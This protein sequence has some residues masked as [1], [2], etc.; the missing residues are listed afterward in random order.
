MYLTYCTVC[1]NLIM[2]KNR[3]KLYIYSIK[4]H[5]IAG[6]GNIDEIISVVGYY[7]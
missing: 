1:R 7:Y 4:L 6:E 2:L 3:N 5:L